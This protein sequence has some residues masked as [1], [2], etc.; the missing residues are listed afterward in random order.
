[1]FKGYN[2][3]PVLL[4][5]NSKVRGGSGEILRSGDRAIEMDCNLRQWNYLAKQGL[6]TLL[7]SLDQTVLDVGF[8][9]E[10]RVDEELPEVI[11]GCA[12]LSYLDLEEVYRWSST[13]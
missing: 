2:G 5:D 12:R 4:R 6:N 9:I 3:K 10:G 7:Q 8:T 1:M 13:V 11:L